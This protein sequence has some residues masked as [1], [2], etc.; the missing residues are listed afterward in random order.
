M[1]GYAL[2]LIIITGGIV[3]AFELDMMKEILV[4][5]VEIRKHLD[6]ILGLSLAYS[7]DRK[8]PWSN[9]SSHPLVSA[10][11]SYGRTNMTS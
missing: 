6:A 5:G 2:E 11:G 8:G 10:Y 9:D 3:V 4:I 7:L 1:L